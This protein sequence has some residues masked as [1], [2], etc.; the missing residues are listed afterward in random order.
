MSD[1]PSRPPDD[2][3]DLALYLAGRVVFLIEKDIRT[4][5]GLFC[6]WDYLAPSE[7]QAILARWRALAKAV[8]E[9]SD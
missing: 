5:P 1:A 8:I 4:E 7:Q 6:F 9:G 3:P 2:H